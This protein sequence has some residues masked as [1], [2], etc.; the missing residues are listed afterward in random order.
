LGRLY[1]IL[2]TEIC[3]SK[4]EVT[5]AIVAGLLVIALLFSLSSRILVKR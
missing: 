4:R 3:L 5:G 1:N 2:L